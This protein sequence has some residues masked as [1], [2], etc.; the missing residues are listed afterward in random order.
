MQQ[1]NIPIGTLVDMYKRGELRLPEIQ[2]HYVWRATRV[3]DLLDSLYRGY[4]SGSILMW[5]T[6]EPVPT[7]DFAIAQ[8][9][10][11]FA[12]RKL[13]LD[14]QQR[15]TSL[16]AVLGGEMVQVRGRKRPIDILFNLDHPEGPPIHDTEITA[17]QDSP[18]T[19]DDEE[20]DEIDTDEEEDASG[21][22]LQEQLKRRTFV[23]AAKNLATLPNWVS[24]TQVF[25]TEG[26]A[27]IL[28]KAGITSFDDPRFQRYSDRLKK[29]RAIKD[30][31]YVVH[32]LERNM[33]YEEVTEIF[34]RVNSLGA[35]LKSSDLAL[36]Q[37]TSR[38]Q[39]LLKELE[40]FQE[41]CEQNWFSID[42]GQLVRAIVVMA[43]KQCLFRTVASTP[44]AVLQAG[45]EEAKEGLRFAINF[46]RTNAGIEDESLLSS[47]MFI[48]VL[49][50]VSRL[51]DNKLTADEQSKLLHWLL[52]ANARGRYSRGS[53]ETLL[54]EDLNIVF[55]SGDIG[56]L[57]AP[58]KRQFGRLHVEPGDLAARGVNSPLFSLA[59]LA[60]KDAGAKDWYSGLGLSLTHQGKLHFIQWHHIIPKSLL[61]QKGYETG[62]INEIANMAFITGQTNRRISNKDASSYLVDVVAKQGKTA[63]E[64][65]CVPTD[66]ELWSIDNYR[67]FLKHRRE[68]LAD[69]MNQFIQKKS[70]ISVFDMN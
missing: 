14:G 10:T 58:V 57:L 64:S 44:P 26:D 18:V 30:Y 31:T 63:L 34:V 56:A 53:T 4:P 62:E 19:N 24:V 8:E 40:T 9:T 20:G 61:K 2:R 25:S 11:A 12:G 70:G 36:A 41:E 28:K 16:T 47:P 29:L 51:K 39:N 33:S 38:W 35:K 15:L 46:L 49:A 5:E 48:H 55:K 66:P 67:G 3:R 17:D 50:A 54:N 21:S 68:A 45:W 65:Q 13:L 1:Q 43:T 37:M 23:V 32:V 69:C 7:R 27:Q 22:G 59:Y 42:L 60:L 6:D 52:V